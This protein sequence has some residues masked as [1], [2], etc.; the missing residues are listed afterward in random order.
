MRKEG[1]GRGAGGRDG[2]VLGTGPC[3]RKGAAGG[4]AVPTR[5]LGFLSDCLRPGAGGQCPR[6]DSRRDPSPRR[7][8]GGGACAGR[9]R[10]RAGPRTRATLV[11][12]AAATRT[13]HPAVRVR[14]WG[15]AGRD[16]GGGPSGGLR[17]RLGQQRLKRP[18]TTPADAGRRVRSPRL[19]M[20]GAGPRVG[21]DD[22][23]VF[24]RSLTSSPVGRPPDGEARRT[25]RRRGS[26]PRKCVDQGRR[27]PYTSPA[28]RRKG[29]TPLPPYLSPSR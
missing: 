14:G 16:R 11:F 21:R 27:V 20:K 7:L 15:G 6:P 2:G 3:R 25:S 19:Y 13:G 8:A 9:G 12:R 23:C 28:T 26:D 17:G 1:P 29:S 24:H 10:G 18:G 22:P 4:V 5:L